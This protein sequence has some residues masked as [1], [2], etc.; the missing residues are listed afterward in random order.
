MVGPVQAKKRAVLEPASL[1]FSAQFH[2]VL[3]TQAETAFVRP[4]RDRF[5]DRV[6]F[7][8]APG[9]AAPWPSRT[10][11]TGSAEY[12]PVVATGVLYG[13][14]AEPPTENESAP[15]DARV[16]ARAEIVADR[17][18][19]EYL[20]VADAVPDE[21]GYYSWV[22]TIDESEQLPEVRDAKLLPAGYHFVDRF[23]LA[24]EGQTV[25]MR[26]RWNTEL[27]ERELALDQLE[28]RDR[29]TVSLEAGEW[30]RDGN[31][32]HLPARLRLT[33][34]A[35]EEEPE[36][37][38][39]VPEDAR[40]LAHSFVDVLT[41][42]DYEAP[43]IAVPFETRGWVTVQ[44]CLL[45]EDQSEAA[46][47]HVEEWC[48]DFGV[49]EET[50]RIDVPTVRTEAQPEV[51]VGDTFR[52]TAVVDG[53]I[54]EGADLGFVYY[55]QPEPQTPK[56]DS[57]WEPV[58]DERGSVVYWDADEIAALSEAELCSAQPVATT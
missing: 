55:L 15:Q 30:L 31:G 36:R 14:F 21:A 35:S 19:G 33:A 17:G 18:P 48:D 53:L 1:E 43:P 12:A 57:S 50:A 4:D 41:A 51:F 26:L 40:E 25:P 47:E 46:R 23:G 28:L 11:Q 39:D 22:W 38:S 16:A 56:Y 49:P 10:G 20:A 44:T 7:G 27:L 45:A 2:P 8:L 58:R 37:R 9:S 24:A 13:P 32:E 6:T 29:I 52:D 54:P 3:S 34:Y 5:A 42:G